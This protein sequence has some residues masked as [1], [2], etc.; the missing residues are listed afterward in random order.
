M[1]FLPFTLEEKLDFHA[2]HRIKTNN[3]GN[4]NHKY[5]NYRI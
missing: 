4:S 1:G 2:L 3:A 5:Y